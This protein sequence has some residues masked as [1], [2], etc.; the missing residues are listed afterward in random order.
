M[1]L[2][3]VLLLLLGAA[4]LLAT[5]PLCVGSTA[6]AA[7]SQR[8]RAQIDALLAVR[9][10]PP[11]LPVDPPN[12]FAAASAGTVVAGDRVAPSL[13][14]G[15]PIAE[16]RSNAAIL[17]RLASRV[18]IGGLIRIN[19]QHQIVINDSPLRE[20]DSFVVEREPRIIQVQVA[21]IAPGQ[22]TLRL[23]DAELT[24]RF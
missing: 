23:E 22:L 5:A 2:R 9:R 19:D 21:R 7:R 15:A 1:K 20:G 18:R 14:A 16:S 24:L 13:P 8:I 4:L 3:P 10:K 12:P 11:P 17:A 6:T